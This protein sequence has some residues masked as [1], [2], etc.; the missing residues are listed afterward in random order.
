MEI[1]FG[2]VVVLFGIAGGLFM[3]WYLVGTALVLLKYVGELA[4]ETL[5]KSNKL[6]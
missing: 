4:E 5:K 6:W 2:T 1:L 3:V